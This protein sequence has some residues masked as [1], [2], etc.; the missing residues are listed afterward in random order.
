MDS[1]VT[2]RAVET[3]V[4]QADPFAVVR[5]E[6]VYGV[7]NLSAD[8]TGNFEVAEHFFRI[9]MNSLRVVSIDQFG[10]ELKSE[11]EVE[12]LQGSIDAIGYQPWG[13]ILNVQ[14]TEDYFRASTATA[15]V[16]DDMT[17]ED[18]VDQLT[19][20]GREKPVAG[21]PALSDFATDN[22]VSEGEASDMVGGN[23][24]L[25]TAELLDGFGTGVGE[26]NAIRINGVLLP[27]PM[28]FVPAE[29][30]GDMNKANE[31]VLSSGES[32]FAHAE[33]GD[34]P[35]GSLGA[36]SG[37]FDFYAVRGIKAGQEL[38]VD[39]NTPEGSELDS[40]IYI[41]DSTGLRVD[42]ND[43]F[44]TSTDSFL[45]FTAPAD[46]DYFIAVASFGT[47][48][49]IN[50][51]DSSSGIG[52]T[53]EGA[54]DILIGLDIETDVDTYAIEVE[55]GDILGADVSGG[56]IHLS[57]LDSEGNLVQ[58]AGHDASYIYPAESPLPRDGN[59]TVSFVAPASGRYFVSVDSGVGEYR[60]DLGIYRPV[61][62]EQNR[63]QKQILF[64]DFDGATIAPR[65]LYG[66]GNEVAELSPLSDFLSNWGL[67]SDDE[68][69]VIEFARARV[70]DT[71][72]ALGS[73][74]NGDFQ[75]DGVDGNF[76][77]EVITSSDFL[78]ATGFAFD[79]YGAANVTRVIIGGT[80]DELGIST[81]GLAES[82]DIGNFD[83]SETAVVLLDLLSG[84]STD[85]N[86]LNQ[87]TLA[88]GRTKA[89]LVGSA[90][91][92]VAIHEAGHLFGGWHTSQANRTN[93]TMDQ[94]GNIARTAG[95]GGD[96]IFGNDNDE[97]IYFGADEYVPN[98]GFT[99]VQDSIAQVAFGLSSGT[100]DHGLQ[101][102]A[103]NPGDDRL[104]TTPPT[105]FS[106]AFLDPIDTLADIAASSLTVN[107]IAANGV[108][109]VSDFELQFTFD[110]SPVAN[111]GLQTMQLEAGSVTRLSD[112]APVNEYSALFGY[113][114]A[115]MVVETFSP[116]PSEVEVPFGSLRVTFSEP[117]LPDSV[118]VDDLELS[119]GIV[120]SVTLVDEVTVEYSIDKL[121]LEGVLTAELPDGA[122]LDQHGHFST[123]FE[124]T[125][126]L[127]IGT[128]PFLTPLDSKLPLGS[129]IYDPTMV[130]TIGS[131]GDSDDFELLVDDGQS[132][133]VSLTTDSVLQGQ[134][135]VFRDGR[136]IDLVTATAPGELVILQ[137]DPGT[138]RLIDGGSSLFTIRVSGAN[139]TTGHYEL[140]VLLNSAF[141]EERQ[142]AGDNDS[143]GSA[144]NLN[145]AFGTLVAN[146]PDMASVLGTLDGETV[147]REDFESGQLNSDYW[148]YK[149]S[150][151]FGV[152]DVTGD[153]STAD[154]SYALVMGV[155]RVSTPNLNEAIW[156]VDLSGQ[157][158]AILTFDHINYS[159][160]PHPFAG[161]FIQSYE[162]DGI[163]ISSNGF[164]WHPIFSAPE[165]RTNRWQS[166]SVDLGQ[167]EEDFGITVF[168]PLMIKFQQFDDF[169]IASDGRGWDNIRIAKPDPADW[170][171]VDLSSRDVLNVIA[172]AQDRGDVQVEVFDANGQQLARGLEQN[173]LLRNSSFE[174]GTL[175]GWR[176]NNTGNTSR[177]WA[178]AAAGQGGDLFIDQTLPQDGDFV[179]WNGFDG[180]I[181]MEM[182]LYQDVQIPADA[183]SPSLTWSQRLQWLFVADDARARQF[184]VQVRDP[185]T[186]AIL[187]TLFAFETPTGAQQRLG[188]TQWQTNSV[189]LSAYVGQEIRLAFHQVI[190][191]GNAGPGQVEL[192]NVQLDLGRVDYTNV[193]DVIENFVAPA[194]GT[195]YVKVS[196][197]NGTDYSLTLA[198]NVGFNLE[199]NDSIESSQPVTIADRVG[200]QW[201]LGYLDQQIDSSDY[202]LVSAEQGLLRFESFL[203]AGSDGEFV[204]ELD[205]LFRLYDANGVLVAED[206]NSG[207]DNNASL[208]YRVPNGGDE[209]YY[210]EVSVSPEASGAATRGEYII[211]IQGGAELLA[212]QAEP[213][214]PAQLP[215]LEPHQPALTSQISQ[216]QKE[217]EVDLVFTKLSRQVELESQQMDQ[218]FRNSGQNN[219]TDQDSR[220][221]AFLDLSD[222]WQV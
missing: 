193:T 9:G 108:Q 159:D 210:L 45:R 39:I 180:E 69:E 87:F 84:P 74:P 144:Q 202:Y 173:D 2:Y 91:G 198:R 119:H 140:N 23:D 58:G 217:D 81:I 161:D 142:I 176:V 34:G 129:L 101:V 64:L 4:G 24:S 22:N 72:A 18:F 94:G 5:F 155:N 208:Q 17:R 139:D 164:D 147:I 131:A 209:T 151:S 30:D 158:D 15:L 120:S 162:A 175:E 181:S 112:A 66:F 103:S 93:Q 121:F 132:L 95:L 219:V 195:Y 157:E 7:E 110:V 78:N 25:E 35:Y 177:P 106:I 170:Y 11:V 43:D 122:V 197:D 216:T 174:S 196:G 6:S 163:A 166:F 221:A 135:E 32:V 145:S 114:A 63:G 90:L 79:P 200:R 33:I 102:V 89:E 3:L 13:D 86:S 186:D 68:Q 71:L 36:G 96:R 47:F 51:F 27:I 137:N 154:G 215:L 204:N 167:I 115:L 199:D 44:G 152:I 143:I 54:Y 141:E 14:L 146:S 130:A 207:S 168:A 117:Y 148:T 185:N 188:D 178:V 136:S 67:N 82:V 88:N 85:P 48:G 76:A 123:G 56:G 55:A 189:D 1:L 165:S 214:D 160:E 138:G 111:E 213:G 42:V 12:R 98:E 220:D 75:S 192:D 109:V 38:V 128:V 125:Y 31:V 97:L 52:A 134:V 26:E 211:S 171:E 28:D 65:E 37:D 60:L 83:T 16:P 127:E 77:Y 172:A 105:E 29:D 46:D 49:P 156:H 150:S 206:D 169:P 118:S 62:E 183:T 218:V 50:P 104:V 40:F 107:G 10:Q 205:V 19:N 184:D 191:E 201:Q 194:N 53:S 8:A 21:R 99:G 182:M 212:V 70:I 153:Y 113:D 179:A 80:I 61:L 20:Y 100:R 133:S 116:G 149:S 190:P 59:A 73:G 222:F 57:I 41:H 203:P 126:E 124:S 92:N 187:E